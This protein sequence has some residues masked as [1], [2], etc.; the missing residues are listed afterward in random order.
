MRLNWGTGVAAAYLLFAIATGGFAAFAMSRPV[1]LVSP[2]YY[3]D[4]LRED[5]HLAASRNALALGGAA[6]LTSNGRDCIDIV[7]PADQ[8]AGATGSIT[9]YRA[10]DP[11]ADQMIALSP[12]RTGRQVLA[13]GEIARGTW[14]VQ[15]RWSAAGR[16]YYLEKLVNLK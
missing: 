2:D 6:G 5:Q 13:V 10:S 14:L 1:L 7:I 11:A 3:A 16:D 9:L 12:D 15:V 4:S 8:A